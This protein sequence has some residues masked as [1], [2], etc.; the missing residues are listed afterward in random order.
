MKKNLIFLTGIVFV[1]TILLA[2]GCG[3]R[4]KQNSSTTEEN[5]PTEVK[6]DLISD[7]DDSTRGHISLKDT[8]YSDGT[9]H[10]FMYDKQSE[11]GVIDDHLIV[12][13]R[14]HTVKW[15]NAKDSKITK[16][17]HIR[18]VGDTSFWGAVPV[19]DSTEGDSEEFFSINRGVFKLVIPNS[20]TLDTLVKYEIHFTVKDHKD[21][22]YI[23]DPYL[24]I[25]EE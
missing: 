9:M 20:A 11:C 2:G 24:K 19:I 6:K 14:N 4:S 8:L 25:P 7:E 16:I 13:K 17:L 15:K 21:T 1:L 10:L 3:D 22:T 12:V 5:G 18:P 23:L